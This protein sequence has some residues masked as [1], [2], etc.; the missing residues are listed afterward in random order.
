MPRGP[1]LDAFGTLHHVI[2]RE[3]EKRHI[4]D[5]DKDREVFVNRMGEIAKD[6]GTFIYGM[7]ADQSCS[8]LATQRQCLYR[9]R[10]RKANLFL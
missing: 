10:L 7:G 3:I 9:R 1:R 4:V 2:V 5:N 8:H 6:M